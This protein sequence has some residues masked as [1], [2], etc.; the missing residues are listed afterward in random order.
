MPA[1]S[2]GPSPRI[3]VA[4][5][6]QGGDWRAGL[7]ILDAHPGHPLVRSLAD[8][9]G[10]E[11]WEGLDPLDTRNAQP[12]VYV[13]GLVA[14]EGI[15]REAVAVAMGHSLGE[16]TAAA[17]AGAIAPDAGLRLMAERALVGRAAHGDRPSSMAAVMR[18]ERADLEAAVRHVV[19]AAPDHVLEVA[20]R[21]SDTQH[22]VSGDAATVAALVERANAAGAVARALPIDG[23]YHCALLAPQLE[24]FA[25]AVDRAVTADAEIPVVGSTA[26]GPWTDRAQLVELIT[27]S[28]VRHVDWPAAVA[29][30]VGAGATTLVDAGPGDT[31]V[32]LARFL[33]QLPAAST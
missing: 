14:A 15:D 32:R 10:T 13:A 28:L 30:A 11:R 7:D 17:W 22:V 29:A 23:G 25:A 27:Q 33:P 24:R 26:P 19:E 6:G 1:E 4:F 12:L 31:I 9:L 3:A 2:T 20:V 5:P 8:L 18:W 21:N 16:I